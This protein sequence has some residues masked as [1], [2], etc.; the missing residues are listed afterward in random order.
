MGD[1]SKDFVGK[2]INIDPTDQIPDHMI[3][4]QTEGPFRIIDTV[5]QV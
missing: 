4:E 3:A 5:C 1:S 2:Y